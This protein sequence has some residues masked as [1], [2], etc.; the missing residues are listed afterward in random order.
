MAIWPFA[1]KNGQDTTQRMRLAMAG[2]IMPSRD[3]PLKLQTGLINDGG[4]VVTTVGGTMNVSITP[5][6]AMIQG[7]VAGTQG[8]YPVIS[9]VAQVVTLPNGGG[10]D[11]QYTIAAIV[12]DSAFDA[13]GQQRARCVAYT[14]A[15]GPP[16]NSGV[17][18]LR[19]INLRAGLS[20]GS[21]GLLPGDLNTDF[22]AYTVAVGGVLPT[23]SS[24][25][26]GSPA[27]GSW[28]YETDTGVMRVWTGAIW[29]A[30]RL[31]V[32]VTLQK[33]TATGTW[34]APADLKAVRFGTQASG[35][36]G[37]GAQAASAAQH[38]KGAGGGAGGWA[39]VY[40]SAAA[41]GASQ[42][43][44]IGAAGTGVSGAAGNNGAAA[45]VG[46]VCAANGGSGGQ[47]GN[48]AGTAFGVQGGA[49]GAGTIGDVQEQG[50]PGGPCWG[51]AG[52]CISG[53]GGRSKRGGGGR[54][55]SSVSAGNSIPGGVGGNYGG[56]GGGGIATS[57]AAACAGGNGGPGIALA[58]QWF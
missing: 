14:T 37:G 55:Q 24:T 46:A 21:G 2:F 6:R 3:A 51:N 45:S 26:P 17:V 25:R 11:V 19:Q 48:N 5:F 43:V 36:A 49:G 10:A 50:D 4:G 27:I 33:F 52:L 12:E 31:D 34:T 18:P 15:G 1:I 57:T 56:G 20:T 47:I 41:A 53:N 35:G 42:A 39:E 22:R 30:I 58:E 16:V 54:G 44:T 8:G 40:L 13:S 9:D 32:L 38:S 23:L 7:T 29:K 28:I